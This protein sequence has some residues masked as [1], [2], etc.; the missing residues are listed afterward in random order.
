MERNSKVILCKSIK[1]DRE[2]TNVLSYSE[3]DMVTLCEQNSVYE[4]DNYSFLRPTRNSI[5]V[6]CDYATCLSA[7]YIAFQNPDYSNKWFFGW[8][9]DINFLANNQSEV[10]FSIDAWSTWYSK[11]TPSKCFINRQHVVDDTFGKN[12]I[13]ENLDV[14]EVIQENLIEPAEYN[15]DTYY[16]AMMT[17]WKINDNTTGA[18]IVGE[19]GTQFDGITTYNNT[20]F[21]DQV[22]LF[23]INSL[24]D[25][26]NVSKYI[27]R[28]NKDGHID[29]IKNLFIVPNA[30]IDQ[31]KI[32]EH[33]AYVIEQ[34]EDAKF[35]FYTI[36]YTSLPKKFTTSFTKMEGFGDYT[37]KN[38]KCYCYPYNYILISNN[39]GS[40][41]IYKYENFTADNLCEF[42]NQL[43]LQ[44]GVSGRIVPLN[45]KGMATADDE[46]L[47]LGKYP[48]CGWSADAYTNWLT[49][50]SV[51]MVTS[52][53]GLTNVGDTKQKLSNVSDLKPAV[54]G[55]LGLNAG[56]TV[57]QGVA[58]TIGEFYSASLEPNIEGNQPTGDVMW[59]A[60][61]NT[62]SIRQ[63]RAKTEYL[64][65]IDDFFTRFGY[66]VKRFEMPN[67][68]HRQNWNYIEIGQNEEIGYGDVPQKYMDI[69]NGACKHR[70]YYL[71]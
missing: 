65:I 31:S 58:S 20:L 64:K 10:V 24:S 8:I 51:N 7:N 71:A 68:T 66:L 9:D 33:S 22:I 15:N 34:T 3:S 46:A 45:Y 32:T 54:L 1:M 60:K 57:A 17:N 41:N 62:F 43:S 69:I 11:W 36:L 39:Q 29:D 47:P 63:M 44:I 59:S 61:R 35:Y 55:G 67:L 25:I 6:S 19:K 70:S 48:T 18:E 52:M 37:P 5:K 56:L 26:A 13:N 23:K 38:N 30:L 49:K 16:I 50:N 28:T 21:G 14:G 12:T 42:E 4:A 40:H 2:Y 27:M 53:I